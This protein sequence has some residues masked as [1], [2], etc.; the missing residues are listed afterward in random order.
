[1]K[2]IQHWITESAQRDANSAALVWKGSR[3]SYREFETKSNQLARLLV[4]SGCR[5]GNR[6]AICL[7]KS[8]EA[9]LGIAAAL[10]ADCIYVPLDT[11]S[12]PARIR[13]ILEACGPRVILTND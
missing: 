11:E 2:L 12:P 7:P 10:K 9:Y 13:K 5:R 6:I 8:P 1:M 3:I 4:E